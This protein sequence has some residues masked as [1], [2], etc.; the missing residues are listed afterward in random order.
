VDEF[1]KAAAA[2]RVAPAPKRQAE[3]CV[4][5]R[6]RRRRVRRNATPRGLES[7]LP[8]GVITERLTFLEYVLYLAERGEYGADTHEQVPASLRKLVNPEPTSAP[9]RIWPPTVRNTSPRPN[10]V[11]QNGKSFSRSIVLTLNGEWRDQ[12]WTEQRRQ[13]DGRL[14]WCLVVLANDQHHDCRADC[15]AE[16]EKITEQMSI[17]HGATD[18]D[19]NAEQCNQT[20]GQRRPCFDHRQ[21]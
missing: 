15:H 5:Y 10:C 6:R 14:H 12:Q 19:G 2:E 1:P 7:Q 11:V 4:T 17:G 3:L 13:T 9:S 16:G 18:H 8:D 20:G 21:P